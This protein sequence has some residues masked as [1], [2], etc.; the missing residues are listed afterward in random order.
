[1]G[2]YK[3]PGKPH[4]RDKGQHVRIPYTMIR[5]PSYRA[6]SADARAI[7]VDMHLGFHGY[8]NGEIAYSLRQA[9]EC[10]HSGSERAKR[11]MDQLQKHGFI[12][13]HSSSSF[14]I[15]QKKRASGKTPFIQ[16]GTAQTA[17]LPISGK[18]N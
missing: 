2:R 5:H 16:C 17:P 4:K 10:L 7:L 11:A 18:N 3:H 6:L 13:C 1:M 15:K 12:V 9:M 14:T 8:N